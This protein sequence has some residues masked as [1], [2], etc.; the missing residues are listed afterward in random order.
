[1]MGLV[2]GVDLEEFDNT[3]FSLTTE[4]EVEGFWTFEKDVYIGKKKMLTVLNVE[5]R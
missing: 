4:Q 5:F 3:R 1:M 2:D